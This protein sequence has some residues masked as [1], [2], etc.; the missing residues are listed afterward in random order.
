MFALKFG[1]TRRHLA[2]LVSAAL[3]ASLLA[4]GFAVTVA[5]TSVAQAAPGDTAQAQCR[6]TATLVQNTQAYEVDL[7]TG[8]S[9]LRNTFELSSNAVGFNQLDGYYYAMGGNNLPNR[10]IVAFS[11]DYGPQI[12]LGQISL[13]GVSSFVNVG[14]IS[15]DGI[16]YV[17]Q[18]GN[19]QGWAAIDV[20]PGSDTYLE[21]IKTGIVTYPPEAIA[22]IADLGADWTYNVKDGAL[23]RIGI[24]GNPSVAYLLKFDPATGIGSRVASLGEL[25]APNGQRLGSN[26]AV[27]AD[28]AGYLYVSSNSNGTIFRV[29]MNAPYDT[30][31]FAY[32]PASS[33]NDGARCISALPID[34]GDAPSSYGTVIVA[35][36][37]R[38]SITEFDEATGRSP[39]M[40]GTSIDTE[41]DGHPSVSADSDDL[42]NR[43]DEDGVVRPAFVLSGR[44]V[45][46]QVTA[47]NELAT[48]ATLAGWMDLDGNGTFDADERVV[49]AIPANS[50]SQVYTLE[51][52]KGE[53]GASYISR[54]RLFSGTVADPSPV[55]AATGGEVEDYPRIGERQP[56]PATFALEKTSDR[57]VNSR[58]GDTITYT[59]K[60]TNVGDSDFTAATPAT[61]F[62]DLTGVLD[63]ATFDGNVM[64]SVGTATYTE[65]RIKWQGPL[66]AGKSV[67][68]TYS[69][70]L[71]GAGDREVKNVAFATPCPEGETCE[72]PTPPISACLEG[73][74]DPR[75]GLPCDAVSYG[76]PAL[77]IDKK[78]DA[79]VVTK[80]GQSVK[81]TVT[82]TNSGTAAYTSERPAVAI[83]DL[84]GVLD[85]ATLDQSTLAASVGADPTF[86]RPK[87]SWSGP[88]AVNGSVNITY[89][90]TYD[91][92]PADGNGK[93]VNVAFGPP[94]SAD[95]PRC[96]TNPPPTPVCDPADENGRDPVTGD[97]CARVEIPTM[98]LEVTKSSDP[99]DGSKVL[100][101]ETIDYTI[102]FK[103]PGP[104]VAEV[105]GWNDYLSGVLDD[106]TVTDQPTSSDPSLLVVSA[107]ENEKFE[108]NGTVP[109]RGEITVKYTV[110]V[111]ADGQRGDDV[112]TNVVRPPGVDPPVRCAA[113]DELCTTHRVPGVVASKSVNPA[114]GTTVKPGDTLTYTLTFTNNGA[115]AGTVDEIDYLSELLDDA[116]I[117]SR[118]TVMD[119]ANPGD[120]ALTVS[121]I[122]D[123]K[124]TIKGTLQSNQTVTVTYQAMV[125]S[126][127]KRGDN[128]ISNFVLRPTTDPPTGP[129]CA[130]DD[131]R[132]T[133]NGVP[134]VVD[135]KSSDPVSGSTVVAGDVITYTLTFKNEGGAPGD[136]NK[137]DDLSYVADDADITSAP[138]S[139]DAALVVTPVQNNQFMIT[140][141]LAAGQTVK[142]T[143]QVKVQPDADR[144]DNK[145]ANYLLNPGGTPPP[146]PVCAD[147]S[148]DCTTHVAPLII[149]SKS[150]NPASGSTV[151]IGQVVTY[152]LTFENRGATTGKINKVD[153]LT[154]V[155]DD[156]SIVSQPTSSRDTVTA[157]AVS[158]ARY[159]ITGT[160]GANQKVTITYQVRVS[161]AGD[162]V[163]ANYLIRPD[164]NPPPNPVCEPESA[165]D[166]D[167]TRHPVP[168]VVIA[169]T[170]DPTTGST[171]EAG[172]DVTYKL[173]VRNTGAAEGTVAFTDHLDDVLDD[174]KLVRRPVS[175]TA[176][177]QAVVDGDSVVLTGSLAPGAT[178]IVTYTFEVLERED[179]GDHQLGNFV[180]TTGDEPPKVCEKDSELCTTHPVPPDLAF[181]GGTIAVGLIVA[182]VLLIVGGGVLV[183]IRRRRT[184]K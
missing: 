75:T 79:T 65:P 92:Q 22:G 124:F 161:G 162:Q 29:N 10:T 93:L 61:I 82:A 155:L 45:S 73:G 9:T 159:S 98:L 33:L 58:V 170:A 136:V 146:E 158:D 50:G 97:P 77:T 105:K 156:A 18:N 123:E 117:T 118:P 80:D 66:A 89:T 160:L 128:I 57:T 168:K 148:E 163:L 87:I 59:V 151:R 100:A 172:D 175:D 11:A 174:A 94:C 12:N 142:V 119:P 64:A 68:L 40:L 110:T 51:F 19:K 62:D 99:V 83:D 71:T 181:T 177:V 116:R 30:S 121:E 153:D 112:I 7:V 184:V 113:D 115:T 35:N 152:T 86:E 49:K 76:I 14:E 39:L 102:T 164:Q 126:D 74:R 145:L 137:V 67:T 41:L 55:G 36:G 131:P 2:A 24:G 25:V 84:S 125:L 70:V 31:F 122:A 81:Y 149:D 52:P 133:K 4:V 144:G 130:A 78:A 179:Q 6:P 107:I 129:E 157:T 120:P 46:V 140:G 132:C 147:G 109:A 173:T 5:P 54:F 135:S 176:S 127:D 150:A 90:V 101:G 171:V 138:S 16:W 60:A 42:N 143:Y 106:A 3:A 96:V 69:V 141:T 43:D 183:T 26:G 34:F 104:T 63:D 13:P 56:E 85:E 17:T 154:H 95:D 37:A 180:T 48:E 32:G 38:H 21:V 167:C 111:K 72:P 23:Y 139:S 28:N 27:Y 169:K 182:A 15:P 178:A 103:N 165:S 8:Q 114:S 134:E 88:L 53:L 47:N 91:A 108:V 166:P 44:P 1:Q 20:R